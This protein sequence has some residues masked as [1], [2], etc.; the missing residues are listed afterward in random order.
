MGASTD[1]Q[2][3]EMIAHDL[4]FY[5]AASAKKT[6]F[7]LDF[8]PSEAQE[9][10]NNFDPTG[11]SKLP[12]IQIENKYFQG[13]TR[14]ERLLDKN[15]VS[16]EWALQDNEESYPRPHN[17]QDFV[18]ASKSVADF[19]CS[20]I[21]KCQSDQLQP[22]HCDQ[23][24]SHCRD[25]LPAFQSEATNSQTS[26][27]EVLACWPEVRSMNLEGDITPPGMD[28]SHAF[29]DGNFDT[30]DSCDYSSGTEDHKAVKPLSKS[31][32]QEVANPIKKK[33]EDKVAKVK[34]GPN[35]FL[36]PRLRALMI[37]KERSK[38]Q[39]NDKQT[40][41]ESSI[42]TI[43]SD[44]EDEFVLSSKTASSSGLDCNGETKV[45]KQKRQSDLLADI[46]VIDS[47]TDG[48]DDQ[49]IEKTATPERLS[50]SV[51]EGNVILGI[52]DQHSQKE[53]ET[54]KNLLI[55]ADLLQSTANCQ[56]QPEDIP[57]DKL[58]RAFNDLSHGTHLTESQE[59]YDKL[60]NTFKPL[61][62]HEST[63][64]VKSRCNSGDDSRQSTQNSSKH[65]EDQEMSLHS[66]KPKPLT[67]G[68]AT[69]L[70]HVSSQP[71]DVWRTG[72][73]KTDTNQKSQLCTSQ[74]TKGGHLSKFKLGQPPKQ[75]INQNVGQQGTHSK[76]LSPSAKRDLST[77]TSK[78]I[79]NRR[80]TCEAGQ[81]S[82]STEGFL[83]SEEP[84]S[85]D[86]NRKKLK[87]VT[88]APA[89]QSPLKRL[90]R[91][92]SEPSASDTS[93]NFAP[94]QQV[95]SPKGF[96]PCVAMKSSPRMKVLED[97]TKTHHPIRI[98]RK[99]YHGTEQKM[100]TATRTPETTNHTSDMDSDGPVGPEPLQQ[101]EVPK[102][103]R[104][105]QDSNTSLMKRCKNEAMVWSKA[106]HRR[107]A[108]TKS[109]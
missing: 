100:E 13:L 99:Y 76:P 83:H 52:P 2:I 54:E 32:S 94:C 39:T 12:S 109:G 89:T 42:I 92:R 70:P 87:R 5:K 93:A 71:T 36:F 14:R 96:S 105:S 86:C 80:R 67:K 33:N 79:L 57:E 60:E 6:N 65:K 29:S 72:L 97:W 26:N 56:N 1:D 73:K 108:Q 63:K 17:G 77:S 40:P 10:N 44:S 62:G 28:E 91:S 19:E 16:M 101:S 8:T 37:A 95:F 20:E 74:K 35:S 22:A 30:E 24:L 61:Q 102:Q 53:N 82:S 64:S 47:D 38:K 45:V 90:A 68:L 21:S 50:C 49:S 104:R 15:N 9:T 66:Q 7:T 34:K 43:D 85:T 11:I 31:F 41:N 69:T 58:E 55:P 3:L 88:F 27:V 59:D 25:N 18:E 98:G 46:I 81:S 107:P 106:I 51:D 78:P 103:R 4:G 84:T 75:S 23:R 48:N